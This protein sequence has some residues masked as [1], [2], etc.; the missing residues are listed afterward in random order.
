[1]YLD[2][3]LYYLSYFSSLFSGYP[4]VVRMTVVMVV[5][6]SIVSI[7]GITRL[8]YVGYKVGARDRKRKVAREY[9]EDKLLFIMKSTSN[10][11]LNE[12][13]RL[14]QYNVSRTRNW[15]L[16]VL[17]D[18]V[19]S[20]K[21]TLN[22]EGVLNE[23][24]YKTCLEALRIMGYWDK[25]IK[26]SGPAKR[27]E[28]LQVVGQIGNGIDIGS[29]TRSTFHKNKHLRKT[30]RDLFTGHDNYDPFKFMEDNFDESFTQ[31]DKL[32]LHSTLIKRNKQVKLPNLLRWIN[33]S[34]NIEYINFILKEVAFFK[35]HEAVPSLLVMLDKQDHD[36]IRTQVIHSIGELGVLSCVPDLIHR[37][38]TE[39][40]IVREGIIVALGELKTEDSLQFLVKE[41]SNNDDANMK[42]I[43]ARSI[44]TYGEE[45]VVELRNLQQNVKNK[46]NEGALLEQI[47]SEKVVVSI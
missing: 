6:L 38:S 37:F 42:M 44:K 32:R 19:L 31:L 24:N 7:I 15:N 26:R 30:A 45:G 10:Y 9:F 5:V 40:N 28:A 3:Y 16:E 14:L 46:Q 47:M 23:V 29:L 36:L 13:R 20:V 39:S 17:T 22:K 35:Q 25:R 12:V 41:Y 18:I 8:L 11:E 2:Y 33:N 1:M 21:S 43:I 4:L 27:R 34:K